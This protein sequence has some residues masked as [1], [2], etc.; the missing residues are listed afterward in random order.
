M[1]IDGGLLTKLLG[2]IHTNDLVFLCGAGLSMAD[3][4]FLPSA[5]VVAKHCY[6][7]W[8]PTEALDPQ[9]EYDIDKLA[10]HFYDR[11]DFSRLFISLIPW[12]L[13]SG[14]PNRGHEAIGDLLVCRA[15]HAAL[16]A[17]F[18]TMIERW[19]EQRKIAVCAAINGHEATRTSGSH[20]PLLK[21]HGCMNRNKA[22]T[23]WTQ[24]QL[25]EPTVKARVESCSQW[26]NLHLPGKHL[27]VVGFWTDW[28]YLNEVLAAAF[29]INNAQ[30]VTVIDPASA[31]ALQSKAPMLWARLNAL[32]GSFV[33]VQKSGAEFLEELRLAYSR[34][35]ARK[36]YALGKPIAYSAGITVVPSA[37]SLSTEQLYD[38]RRDAEGVP[39]T[40]AASLKEPI[41]SSGEAAFMHIKLIESGATQSG[42][43]FETNGKTIRVVNGS[44]RAL[45]DVKETHKEPAALEQPD[46]VICAGAVDL[47]VPARLIASGRGASVVSPAAGGNAVWLSSEK[48]LLELGI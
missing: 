40:T 3:P 39:Y 42:A 26:M 8:L 17:N 6:D 23:L 18:D 15:V 33:H 36:F 29:K 14:A 24:G 48:A 19:A 43:W 5:A 10:G 2:A 38:L 35:W 31:E 44:G 21:F 22:E 4:S 7:K 20:A 46:I 32:S 27:V 28:G 1:T 12:N 13:L 30:S 37:D 16:S 45:N 41:S 9:L 11:G 34:A 25:G 47:G